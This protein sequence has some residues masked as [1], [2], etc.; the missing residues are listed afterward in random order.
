[1]EEILGLQPALEIRDN[2][3]KYSEQL[4]SVAGASGEV[5]KGDD[6]DV[7]HGNNIE[8]DGYN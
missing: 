2:A 5:P 7:A 8:G 1:M 4:A 3:Q 6:L